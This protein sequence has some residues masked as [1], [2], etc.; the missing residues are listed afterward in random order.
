[1]TDLL[2]KATKVMNL[3]DDTK[4]T[5]FLQHDS[6]LLALDKVFVNEINGS[7]E[8]G[9]GSES[10][11]YKTSL[12]AVT[13]LGGTDQA[14]IM[15]KKEGSTEYA[16]IA[17]SAAKKLQKTLDGMRKKEAKAASIASSAA[18]VKDTEE[19]A[20][21]EDASLPK[22][23]RIKIRQATEKRGIRV[24]VKG[25]VATARIQS[26][27]LVF[28]DLRDGSDIYLQCVLPKELVL[29]HSKYA[30]DRPRVVQ[31][32]KSLLKPLSPSTASSLL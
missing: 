32:K 21:V 1:M 14:T 30:N 24:V 12:H 23:E 6:P 18:T 19:E 22:A 9:S 31:F 15:I 11:P 5:L 10:A 26:R 29:S 20:I 7:D 13:Q 27:K 8:S 4:R 25:W 3:T 16:E 2:T 28:L 17:K